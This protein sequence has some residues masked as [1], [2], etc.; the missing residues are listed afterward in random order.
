ML[1]MT[2]G[3]MLMMTKGKMLM[4][5]RKRMKMKKLRVRRKTWKVIE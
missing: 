3:K 5:V 2:K 4:T 1:M